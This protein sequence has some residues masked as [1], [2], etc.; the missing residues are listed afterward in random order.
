MS[1]SYTEDD[2]V[3]VE[4]GD[5][6]RAPRRRARRWWM[7]LVAL[8]GLIMAGY[9][10][11]ATVHIPYFTQSPGAAI[12]LEGRVSVDGAPSFPSDGE[13]LFTTVRVGRDRATLLEALGAW[14]D[15]AAVLVD[16]DLL[17]GDRTPDENR[18]FNQELMTDSQE[19]A[20]RVALEYL[21][22]DVIVS[23]GALITH[24]QQ[25]SPADGVVEGGDVVVGV[26]DSPVADTDALVD[27]IQSRRPGDEIDLRIRRLDSGEEDEISVVLADR[28]G[29]AFMGVGISD[30]FEMT[31]LPFDIEV[32]TDQVGGPSAGLALTL[33]II[34]VL[35]EGDLTG[36]LE[37]ATTGTIGVDGSIG[38]IGGV[39]QKAHAVRRAGSDVFLVPRG[40]EDMAQEIV[41][42][43]IAVFG[44]SDL[45]D[46]LRALGSMGGDTEHLALP[47]S[48]APLSPTS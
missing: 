10:V 31:D 48:V 2:N 1:N 18:V 45:D 43:D 32:D 7:A 27:A 11:L 16:E 23:D 26:D 4:V 28:D 46:A 33:A 40:S 17:L 44:V 37:V 34:D 13:L 6:P 5:P 41:G 24:V 3:P 14:L 47:P 25:D 19:L 8:V 12:P 35:T 21:G 22:L 38:P 15:P 29:E 36:G 9:L 20:K 30:S 42:D 39:E